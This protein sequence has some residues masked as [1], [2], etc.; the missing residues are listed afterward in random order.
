MKE[1]ANGS[2]TSTFVTA[3]A[4]RDQRPDRRHEEVREKR[5]S[6]GHDVV[7]WAQRRDGLHGRRG[8]GLRGVDHLRALLR[9]GLMSRGASSSNQTGQDRTGQ[10][11]TLQHTS[12]PWRRTERG[13]GRRRRPGVPPWPAWRRRTPRARPA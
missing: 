6:G 2:A 12:V 7:L 9:C 1:N 11:E 5:R 10:Y 3:E 13:R 4:G 8:H